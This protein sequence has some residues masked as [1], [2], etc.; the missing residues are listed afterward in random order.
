MAQPQ[1]DALLKALQPVA[2]A[3][4]AYRVRS[5]DGGASPAPRMSMAD[6][7]VDLDS[8]KVEDDDEVRQT[9]PLRNHPPSQRRPQYVR[10]PGS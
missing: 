8:S 2:Q 4:D 7:S 1:V 3:M 9:G 10:R 5:T 6:V